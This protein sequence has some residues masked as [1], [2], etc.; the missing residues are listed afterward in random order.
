MSPLTYIFAIPLVAAA[1]MVVIP[2]NFRFIIQ[3]LAIVATFASMVVAIGVFC[4]FDPSLA[5]H[6]FQFE[7]KHSW[8]PSIGIGYHVGVDGINLGLILMGTIV[9]FAA[10]WVSHRITTREKEFYI[11]L[12][13]M[14][15]GILG[16][17][18]SL[19]LFSFY[20]FH[21]LALVPTFIMIGVWGRGDRRN[22]AAFQITLYLSV[23]ALLVL[24][25]LLGLYLQLPAGARTF[26]I[27]DITQYF[28]THSMDAAA[29]RC[30]YPL[31]LFGFGILVSLWPF[32]TWA[33]L[34]YGSAP[35]AT[36]MLHAG[37]IKK[38]GLY[39]LI[40]IALPLMPDEAQKWVYILSVL[41]L[42]N[43]LYCG[44]VAMRQRNINL[45]IGNS[46]VAHMGFAFLGIASLS[47]IG[48]TGTVLIMVAHGFLAALT[49]ALS[50]YVADETKT[51]DMDKMG[52][53]L[54]SLP[55][56][57]GVMIMAMLAGC[58]VPGFANFPGEAMVLFGSW[59]RLDVVTLLAVWGALVIAGVY[60]LRAIRRVW[61][62]E[63]D[64]P[65][66]SD[67]GIW[68]K[69]PYALLLACLLVF[70]CYPSLLTDNIEASVVPVVQMANGQSLLQALPRPQPRA[71]TPVLRTN[72][73]SPTP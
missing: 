54:R 16:A 18:A 27:V 38:F 9:A 58:G 31:L 30:I 17:F 73:Q 1:L 53:L 39:G 56:I 50:G 23:G 70:G 44:L 26:D 28:K 52:G 45:L 67:A 14:S 43:I 59:D 4:H 32:H 20:F 15:G 8:A 22:Y 12:M 29:A 34:G 68:S 41:C 25:G 57:G 72:T 13:L 19:D 3:I 7:E 21:E 60:M 47:T 42:G 36:A 62:G 10:T 2:R 71:R 48:I 46:S 5:G 24:I 35:T 65:E 64:W 37:V 61:H 51:L 66:I 69:I 40:R 63:K 49:F 55:F 33:P 11:L 6:G